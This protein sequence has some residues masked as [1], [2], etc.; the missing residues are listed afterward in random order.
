MS[1]SMAIWGV[2][3]D[4]RLKMRLLCAGRRCSMAQL[5]EELVLKAWATDQTI[6]DKGPKKKM[7]HIINRW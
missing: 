4:I 1:K 6:P 3:D 7:K 5:L 2:S